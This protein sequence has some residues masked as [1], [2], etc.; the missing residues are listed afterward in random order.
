MKQVLR[1]A[2]Y[3]SKYGIVG[4]ANN[5]TLYILFVVLVRLGLSPV[6]T[7]GLCYVLGVASSYVLNRRWTFQSGNAHSQDLPR[8]LLA[9]GVGLVS[10]LITI[11]ILDLWLPA[12]VAQLFNIAI[13]AV[14]I[15]LMLRIMRFGI[16]EGKRAG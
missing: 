2:K 4:L 1:E 8:F 9:Y 3:V 16:G 15:F 12:E 6:V 13:T 7:A 10:T 14:V 5:V 11:A